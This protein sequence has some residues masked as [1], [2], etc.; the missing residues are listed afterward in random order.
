MTRGSTLNEKRW[1]PSVGVR[2]SPAARQRFLGEHVGQFL[3]RLWH[4]LSQPRAALSA[5]TSWSVSTEDL[6][7]SCV[8]PSGRSSIDHELGRC[9]HHAACGDEFAAV[10]GGC[11]SSRTSRLM[12]MA[13]KFELVNLGC[14]ATWSL[15]TCFVT[16]AQQSQDQAALLRAHLQSR[17]VFKCHSP[18]EENVEH[19]MV[20]DGTFCLLPPLW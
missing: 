11:V 12:I 20:S 10:Y 5:A 19:G 2:L 16:P 14:F 3:A 4:I 18:F 7:A 6:W 9:T 15:S 1:I 8:S 13:I 17:T